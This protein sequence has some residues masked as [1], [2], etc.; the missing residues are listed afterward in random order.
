MFIA[1][2]EVFVLKFDRPQVILFIAKYVS[3]LINI[4]IVLTVLAGVAWWIL[5]L[6]ESTHMQ[7]YHH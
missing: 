7:T 1:P 4:A 2:V 6:M 5:Q 3:Y